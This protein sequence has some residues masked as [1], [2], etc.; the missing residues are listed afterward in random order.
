VVPVRESAV[1]VIYALPDKH[2]DLS[3]AVATPLL[4]TPQPVVLVMLSVVVG[5]GTKLPRSVVN[6][7]ILLHTGF[8]QASFTV[9]VMIAVAN[10]SARIVVGARVTVNV[11]GV[12]AETVMFEVSLACSEKSAQ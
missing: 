5:G 2:P 11:T 7:T 12:L 6:V 3:V 10:P 1:T 9:A 4:V 8:S